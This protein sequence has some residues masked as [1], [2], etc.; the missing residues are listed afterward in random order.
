M[1]LDG[2]V[3]SIAPA[4]SITVQHLLLTR[5]NVPFSAGYPGPFLDEQWLS[6]RVRL[7]DQFCFPSVM[8]QE[9]A[10]FTWL[11]FCHGDTPV[12]I[13]E[14]LAS[15]ERANVRL[16]WADGPVTDMLVDAAVPEGA[17]DQW[18]AT[19]RFDSDDRKKKTAFTTHSFFFLFFFI[20]IVCL[21]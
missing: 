5:F 21:C 8:G 18:L 17:A 10:E 7:F 19:T 15:Y 1:T 2:G 9:C 20:Q 11:I 3:R 4:E 13:R 16:V 14:Q 12:A 6:N